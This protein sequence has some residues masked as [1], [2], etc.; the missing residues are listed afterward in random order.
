MAPKVFNREYLEE[1]LDVL[2]ELRENISLDL[3][4]AY[5]CRLNRL[6]QR[7]KRQLIDPHEADKK[8]L[9]CE[10]TYTTC[11]QNLETCRE[12][13]EDLRDTVRYLFEH[14]PEDHPST[15]AHYQ[16]VLYSVQQQKKGLLHIQDI[17]R[18]PL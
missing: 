4:W 3:D 2:W 9:S 14:S 5:E 7:V 6:C 11:V 8:R 13:L 17:L 15:H 16:D 12:N 10:F 1:Y 18:S